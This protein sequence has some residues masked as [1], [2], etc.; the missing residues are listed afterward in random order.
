MSL[1]QSFLQINITPD[2]SATPR[3]ATLTVGIPRRAWSRAHHARRGCL[4]AARLCSWLPRIVSPIYYNHIYI[5]KKKKNHPKTHHSIL[6]FS[7][8][9]PRD[10]MADVK[11]L[12]WGY[13]FTREIARRMSIFRG[14]PHALHPAFAPGSPAQVVAHAEGPVAFD[15]PRIEYSE[16][17]ERA[18]EAYARAMSTCPP[19]PSIFIFYLLSSSPIR[20]HHL[21]N[22]ILFYFILFFGIFSRFFFLFLL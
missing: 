8:A 10:R 9:N 20:V 1:P 3:H 6:F 15:A 5:Y 7:R 12:T 14:E 19:P 17:D 13:K 11:L 21:P 4:R 2:A 18:L 16:E 22:F